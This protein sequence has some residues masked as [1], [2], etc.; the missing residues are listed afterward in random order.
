MG[1]QD[2]NLCPS[3]RIK[4]KRKRNRVPVSCT[5]CRRR[6]VKCDKKKPICTNCKKNGV[7][8]LCYYLEPSWAKPLVNSE[9]LSMGGHPE[10][11]TSAQT[12]PA[13]IIVNTPSNTLDHNQSDS[14]QKDEEVRQLRQRVQDLEKLLM[15]KG[16]TGAQ[17]HR[18]AD[19][20]LPDDREVVNLIAN[21]DILYT[22]RH[23]QK[24]MFPL[25]YKINIFSWLFI[26]KTDAYLN[27]LWQ[28]I[29]NLRRHYEY[30]YNNH[31]VAD[32]SL[33]SLGSLSTPLKNSLS[34]GS[35]FQEPN[36]LAVDFTSGLSNSSK[37]PFEHMDQ[38]NQ[39]DFKETEIKKEVLSS[40]RT[41][42]QT[43]TPS[44]NDSSSGAPPTSMCPVTGE[45]GQ[46]PVSGNMEKD[47]VNMKEVNLLS[48]NTGKCPVIPTSESVFPNL[49]SEEDK[50]EPRVCPLMIGDARSLF[51]EKLSKLND[52]NLAKR[53]LVASAYNSPM[54]DSTNTAMNNN[55][56]SVQ[57]KKS[58]SDESKIS[59][60]N[61][62][63]PSVYQSPLTL[64]PMQLDT[65][66]DDDKW[67]GGNTGCPV[68]GCDMNSKKPK[69]S[70]KK[71]KT[72]TI[73]SVKH[74]NYSNTKQA[75]NIIEKNIPPRKVCWLLVDRFF[76]LLY[77]QFPC[78][79]E[80]SFRKKVASIIGPKDG[81]TNK[82]RLSSLGSNY[83]EDF[84]TVCLL[85]LLIRLSWLSL[86]INLA[87]KYDRPL[88]NE[89]KIMSKPEN[90]VPM[91]LVDLIKEIFTNTKM[92]GKP[93]IVILQV[94]IFLKCYNIFSPE[95][96]FD[97]DD[98]YNTSS[99]SDATGDI[100]SESLNLNSINFL[101]S[102]VT[103]AN[104]IGIN[105]DPLFYRNFQSTCSNDSQ[106]NINLFRKRHLWRKLWFTLIS[107]NVVTNISLG[108]YSK[109]L[110]INLDMDPV[111]GTQNKSWDCKLPGEVESELLSEAFSDPALLERELKVVTNYK[112]EYEVNYT[113][114]QGMDLLI[115]HSKV[116]S[117]ENVDLVLGKLN[118]IVKRDERYTG[119][120]TP[121]DM[122]TEPFLIFYEDS[123]NS[124][125]LDIVV[126]IF[127]FRL[128]LTAKI[129]LFVI[130]YIMFINYEKELQSCPEEKI[131]TY[132]GYFNRYFEDTLLL[133]IEDYKLFG[134]FFDN[135]AK[136]FPNHGGEL[137][138]YPF[139]MILNHRSNQFLISIILRLQQDSEP[140]IQ[141]VNHNG[142]AR[143]DLLMRLFQYLKNFLEKLD[144]LTKN[145]Y[146]AWRL[147][148]LIRFFYNVLVNSNRL[149]SINFDNLNSGIERK[150]IHDRKN[151]SQ[152]PSATNLFKRLKGNNSNSS[153][154]VAEP[155]QCP[156][157]RNIDTQF[158]P[159]LVSQP[160]SQ[161][162]SVNGSF[163][164]QSNNKG[165]RQSIETEGP[166]SSQAKQIM[167]S[168]PLFSMENSENIQKN[169]EFLNDNFFMDLN[170]F[171]DAVDDLTPVST[172]FPMAENS[173]FQNSNEID[174]TYAD[175][176]S[177]SRDRFPAQQEQQQQHQ[178]PQQHQQH[179]QQQQQHHQHQK[180]QQQQSITP[181][182]QILG[183]SSNLPNDSVQRS[184]PI[185][186]G[187]PNR[188]GENE[189]LTRPFTQN[190][191]G[192]EEL[193]DG[194]QNEQLQPRSLT[195]RSQEQHEQHQLQQRQQQSSQLGVNVVRMRTGNTPEQ[196]P[197]E[198]SQQPA[199]PIWNYPY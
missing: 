156:V 68:L 175:I 87:R 82:I 63:S 91:V 36:T 96:G 95:D 158:V 1:S 107:L 105:R 37:R 198:Q 179:Q 117:K 55:P 116:P 94:G 73:T 163:S 135:S 52:T 5:I 161:P 79:D 75:I 147:K 157:F 44:S 102:L 62:P 162:A 25:I 164:H 113:I 89:E 86:P 166:Q 110:A 150:S 172:S 151:S 7:P 144:Q 101:S 191:T 159:T 109:M 199:A 186:P 143:D 80:V 54:L 6:K 188:M 192:Q 4:L 98:S 59:P 115:N 83:N 72:F 18:N 16:D 122:K 148:K 187:S 124:S 48:G 28:K 9:L 145:Y 142:I 193:Q 40:D 17:I 21:S 32:A 181:V 197:Q 138:L 103:L 84:M 20:S 154:N 120:P 106:A 23:E 29:F 78:I 177:F 19:G 53:A 111:M 173:L 90:L 196:P 77:L 14:I 171:D 130:N 71:I 155:V 66:Q 137:M 11:L 140:T 85:I 153:N 134:D 70:K 174:F 22:T 81:S 56:G 69:S 39:S 57:M 50:N 127:K 178:Q 149:F 152:S 13:S 133:A 100:T 176:S 170:D 42:S 2:E 38:S 167:E 93:S 194:H 132:Q 99:A 183:S 65:S 34:S 180:T 47:V 182:S 8:H 49:S 128:F 24:F 88:T 67:S 169:I 74:L 46:C 118:V 139:L 41:I 45:I 51:R 12:V 35:N 131:A 92:F 3:E 15:E 119:I 61:T 190:Y 165:Y 185:F 76:D 26:T 33:A 160:S 30:Y 112:L 136:Y 58:S 64:T 129:L 121:W 146:Y 189:Q 27:D 31:T 168:F 114:F 184:S 195:P 141:L 43:T 125:K 104:T 108:D 97:L 123:S 126:R 60:S 10:Q